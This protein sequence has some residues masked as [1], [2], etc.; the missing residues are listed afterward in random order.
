MRIVCMTNEGQIPMMKNML[1]SA[2]NVGIPMELFHCY[3]VNINPSAASYNTLEFQSLTMKKLETI[4]ENMLLDEEVFWVDNDIYFFTNTINDLKSYQGDFVMQDDIFMPCTGFFLIRSNP[5]SIEVI[6]S[7]IDLL[8]QN[9]GNKFMNDQHA[10]VNILQNTKNIRVSV[11]PRDKYP[12]GKVYFTDNIRNNALMV[13]NN[14]LFTY[15][16]K[17]ARFK[18][19]NMWNETDKAFLL[20][21]KINLS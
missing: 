20:V 16:E 9:I 4:L 2:L 19:F 21:D 15:D 5:R 7:A 14:F 18:E 3:F 11:L 10:V 12:V 13:H 6:K 8:R 1:N 17:V